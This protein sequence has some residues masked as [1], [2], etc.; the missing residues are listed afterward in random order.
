M[1]I[2]FWV[3]FF[4]VFGFL[5]YVVGIMR[6]PSIA[7]PKFAQHNTIG[8]LPIVEMWDDKGFYEIDG[9]EY[10]VGIGQVH[11]ENGN[12][13]LIPSGGFTFVEDGE[14]CTQLIGFDNKINHVWSKK[15]CGNENLKKVEGM[16]RSAW[17]KIQKL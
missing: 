11:D 17:R 6:L 13:I 4:A 10:K 1:K 3:L 12:T 2:L 7:L 9:M 15:V 16:F 14:N 8:E 5:I